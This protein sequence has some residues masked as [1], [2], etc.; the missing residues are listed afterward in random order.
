M[1]N[2]SPARA[3]NA[4]EIVWTVPIAIPADDTEAVVSCTTD[5]AM[6]AANVAYRFFKML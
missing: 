2:V 4:I 3:I 6:V 1:E 5:K